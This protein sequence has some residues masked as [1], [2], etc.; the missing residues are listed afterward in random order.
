M[1]NPFA[2]L[3][4]SPDA[5]KRDI[6]TAVA[7]A[8]RAGRFDARRIAEAQKILFDPLTRAVAEFEHA[9]GACDRAANPAPELPAPAE[10]PRLQRLC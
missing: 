8:L 1:I 6:L 5:S 2:V 3:S 9:L 7:T 10:P 4:L